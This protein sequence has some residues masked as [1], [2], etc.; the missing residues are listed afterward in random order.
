MPVKKLVVLGLGTLLFGVVLFALHFFV[1]FVEHTFYDLNFALSPDKTPDSVVI[2]GIDEESIAKIGGFPWPRS[3]IADLVDKIDQ[4]R[5]KVIAMDFFFPYRDAPQ[6]ND[7]LERVFSRVSG[8]VLPF[9]AGKIIP[10][11][12]THTAAIP[13]SALKHRFLMVK[14]QQKLAQHRLYATG[15]I[16]VADSRFAVHAKRSGFV[17]VSTNRTSQKLREIIHVIRAGKEYFPSFAL[18]A[19]AS[20]LDV[21]PQEFVLDGRPEVRVGNHKVPLT[22]YAASTLLNFRGRPGT[23]KT[24]SASDVI[25]GKVPF[26]ALR[27]KLVFVGITDLAGAPDLFITPAGSSF[28]GVEIW[29]T[30]A[31]DILQNAWVRTL[32]APLAAIQWLLVLTIFPGLALFIPDQR[33]YL[34]L[35]V[36]TGIVV[37][38]IILSV[39][40][41]RTMQT[42]WNPGYYVYAWVFSLLW[43]AAQKADPSLMGSGGIELEPVE[44]DD[45]SLLPPKEDEFIQTIPDSAT[46]RH[47]L[48]NIRISTPV[49]AMEV[50]MGTIVED[51]LPIGDFAAEQS[52]F[53]SRGNGLVSEFQKLAGGRI[54]KMLGSGGMADV[55]LVWNPRMDVYRAIKVIKPGQSSHLLDRFET[56]IRI[57]ANLNHPNIVQCYNAG[58]WFDLP[59]L[60]MEFI[61]GAGLDQILAKCKRLSPEQT[62]SVGVLVCRALHYAHQRIVSVYGQT[63]KGVIHRDLKPANIMLSRGGR[64]KLTDFGIARPQAVS[65]HTMDSGKVVGTLPYLAPEQL[66]GKELGP[67]TDIYALG[68]TLFE[69]V[70]GERAFPQSDITTLVNAKTRGEIHRPRNSAQIPTPLVNVIDKAMAKNPQNRFESALAMGREL[71]RILRA[72]SR[73]ADARF[74]RSL[75]RKF[76]N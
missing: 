49:P 32:N 16:D 53:S 17:N 51:D 33:R 26:G 24:V 63:Y 2:V 54:V 14:N 58:H 35:M 4:A 30:A 31:I 12:Q 55:Y 29:A 7:S 75:V 22:S 62:L 25:A 18:A 6:E 36:G 10:D 19:A 5:P 74:L 20:F 60:E 39:V 61:P 64:I 67:Y 68:A 65:L 71:E 40:L 56:E 73:A 72:Q 9:R 27:G 52:P 15:R 66:D 43:L 8:L 46:A 42:F 59:Y 48:E 44:G 41:F 13:P 21:K 23:I 3:T 11:Q 57:F 69:L 70:T 45:D 38:A 37:G 76:W 50:P 28:P 1:P 34:S 47:A